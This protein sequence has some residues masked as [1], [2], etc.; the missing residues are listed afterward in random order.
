MEFSTLRDLPGRP[1]LS[2]CHRRSR[3]PLTNSASIPGSCPR[4]S[5]A[6]WSGCPRCPTRGI[7]AACGTLWSSCSRRPRARFWPGRPPC[8]PSANGWIA[9]APPHVL[10]RLG[11]RRDPLLPMRVPPAETTVRRLPARIDGDALDQA[12]GRR[13]ADRRGSRAGE[14]RGRAVDGKSLRGAARADGRKIHC[15]PPWSTPPA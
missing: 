13:F 14:L 8:R 10:E 11:I 9:D 3:L 12:V 6:C 15:S 4:R 7:H 1:C 5:P 2:K